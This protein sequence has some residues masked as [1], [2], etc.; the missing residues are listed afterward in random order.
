MGRQGGAWRSPDRS[1]IRL[2]IPRATLE[3]SSRSMSGLKVIVFSFR[4]ICCCHGYQRPGRETISQSCLFS[5]K[6]KQ[7]QTNQLLWS[8]CFPC[9]PVIRSAARVYD[10]HIRTLHQLLLSSSVLPR[11]FSSVILHIFTSRH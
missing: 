5:S 8:T 1:P 6:C 3:P 7:I 10:L 2:F 11:V 4:I 9:R